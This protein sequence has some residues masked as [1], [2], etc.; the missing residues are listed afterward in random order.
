MGSAMR[1][2][3]LLLVLMC[4]C[5]QLP[6]P[7][8]GTNDQSMNAARSRCSTSSSRILDVVA[9][10]STGSPRTDTFR[11]TLSVPTQVCVRIDSPTENG[12]RAT[13][14]WVTIDGISLLSPADLTEGFAGLEVPI[15]LSAGEH[16]LEVR[17][18]SKPGTRLLVHLEAMSSDVC[19]ISGP[20]IVVDPINS[21]TSY[22]PLR[23]T[24]ETQPGAAIHVTGG[25]GE[26]WATAQADGRFLL[27]VPLSPNSV[28]S[29]SVVATDSCGDSSPPLA[30]TVVHDD[31]H[32][33]GR[34]YPDPF[35][36]CAPVTILLRSPDLSNGGDVASIHLPAAQNLRA[37]TRLAVT[38]AVP[39][40]AT[41]YVAQLAY[42]SGQQQ[43]HCSYVYVGSSRSFELS[44]CDA[45]D[46]ASPALLSSTEVSLS[47]LGLVHQRA[48]S[49]R[50]ELASLAPC[51]GRPL[52]GGAKFFDRG[53]IEGEWLVVLDERAVTAAAVDATAQRLAQQ[54]G[55]TVFATFPGQPLGF[56]LRA[57]RLGART[58][59]GD[60]SVR[61]VESNVPF[62]GAGITIPLTGNHWAL[63][64]MD[65]VGSSPGTNDLRFR[66]PAT[67]FRANERP[68]LYVLDTQA[69]LTHGFLESV[70]SR[71]APPFRTQCAFGAGINSG[72]GTAV[73]AVAAGLYGSSQALVQELVVVPVLG[74]GGALGGCDFA[75][76]PEVVD[77]LTYTLN[78]S[79]AGDVVNMS[80]GSP[81]LTGL[82][83]MSINALLAG[84]R[85]VVAAAGNESELVSY[86]PA[87]V[88]SVLTVGGTQEADLPYVRTNFGPEVELNAPA[89][90]VFTA[91]DATDSD[92]ANAQGTSVAS[93]LVAGLAVHAVL[94]GGEPQSSL[95]YVDAISAKLQADG[96]SKVR[97]DGRVDQLPVLRGRVLERGELVVSN[98]TLPL[99]SAVANLGSSLFIGLK[100]SASTSSL[101]RIALAPDGTPVPGTVP[102]SVRNTASEWCSALS[103]AWLSFPSNVLVGCW[104]P[105]GSTLVR[106][107]ESGQPI[108]GPIAVSSTD[109]PFKIASFINPIANLETQVILFNSQNGGVASPR[110][111]MEKIKLGVWSPLNTIQAVEISAPAGRLIF[112]ADL[113]VECRAARF[114]DVYVT[115]TA[116]LAVLPPGVMSDAVVLVHK[117]VLDLGS[118]VLSGPE[119]VYQR[120]IVIPSPPGCYLSDVATGYGAEAVGVVADRGSF[121]VV[122]TI[123][124]TDPDL[125]TAACRISGSTYV[126]TPN[127]EDRWAAGE[128]ADSISWSREHNTALIAGEVVALDGMNSTPVVWGTDRSLARRMSWQRPNFVSAALLTESYRGFVLESSPLFELRLRWFDP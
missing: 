104:A 63:D 115:S 21:L 19:P 40:L 95:G 38:A 3:G 61:F 62:R 83:E 35:Q 77:G 84:G 116:R 13:S 73:A 89:S 36:K 31:V 48:F 109:V 7:K 82:V 123:G 44:H 114:C 93:P 107:N 99:R 110:W 51:P 11:F 74:L 91:S 79:R 24:G 43:N 20:S 101:L 97:S 85:V 100:A 5:Q 1:M 29:L 102:I 65:Q 10:R 4:G 15:P 17:V 126:A 55:G 22:N 53:G 8:S 39:D 96:V 27:Q 26:G 57:S 81:I 118:A 6:S 128:F 49:V 106:Y 54:A 14:G 32:P 25:A 46:G 125:V 88:P 58:V 16:T 50:A 45:A 120:S 23:L 75:M 67:A 94:A 60:S 112:G 86:P 12:H 34:A 76:G 70:P 80:F 68:R 121:T 92:P 113:S 87:N 78:D 56:A 72:H 47:M 59:A 111:T 105:T 117:L 64:R 127:G 69:R 98:Q 90:N 30:L 18:V 119:V 108:A 28:N 41:G 71:Q 33:E 2:S 52:L 9:E 66:W 42:G 122:Y 103:P 37:P 124:N